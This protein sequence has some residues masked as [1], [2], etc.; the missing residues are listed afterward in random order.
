MTY[1]AIEE[2]VEEHFR[3]DDYFS[4]EQL[5]FDVKQQFEQ[6]GRYFPEEAENNIRQLWRETITGIPENNLDYYEGPDQ[7]TLDDIRNDIR[8]KFSH[9]FE[10]N[11]FPE[12]TGV[13][14]IQP[15]FDQ[16]SIQEEPQVDVTPEPQKW[17]TGGFRSLGKRIWKLFGR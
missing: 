3:V 10:E 6:D 13:P 2:W 9:F 5:I 11:V 7:E 1:K 17:F 8:E 16:Q 12:Y 4:D 14:D 15:V